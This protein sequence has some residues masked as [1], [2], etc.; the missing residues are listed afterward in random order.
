MSRPVCN[1]EAAK[2]MQYWHAIVVD[3]TKTREERTEAA[4]NFN[5]MNIFRDHSYHENYP[6]SPSYHC[7]W[8]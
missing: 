2:L 8:E 5:T 7:D 4:K 3:P 6:H 1:K